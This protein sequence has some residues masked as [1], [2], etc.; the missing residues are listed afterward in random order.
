MDS[1]FIDFLARIMASIGLI[2]VINHHIPLN[3]WECCGL[4]SFGLLLLHGGMDA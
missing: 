1:F 3:Y 2:V 4:F